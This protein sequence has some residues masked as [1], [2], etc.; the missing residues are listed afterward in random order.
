MRKEVT[1]TQKA[2][3]LWAIIL[4]VWSVYRANF[5][6]PDW[7]DEFIAKPAIFILPVYFFIKNIEKKEFLSTIY[8]KPKLIIRDLLFGV[9]VGGVFIC[10]A[11]AANYVKFGRIIF[12][13]RSLAIDNIPLL[14]LMA[15]ATGIS[16]EILSR[17]FILEKLYNE[18][19]NIFSASF[20]ASILFF[21]LHVPILFG[22]LKITGNLL[23]LFMASDVVLSLVLSFLFLTRKSLS[24]PIFIHAFYNI[25]ITLFV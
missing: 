11:L 21:F 25:I 4:I 20:F 1:I 7:I 2:L 6:M 22:S 24:L 12:F 18:S 19:K 15:L 10:S 14:V 9:V 23:L 8:L 13:S 16:E 5:Q 17:G 3:N